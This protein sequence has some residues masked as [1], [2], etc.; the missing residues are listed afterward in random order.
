MA[1]ATLFGVSFLV[2]VA[3]LG[4]G[5]GNSSVGGGGGGAGGGAGGGV[6]GGAGGGTGQSC[7]PVGEVCGDNIDN[8][9]DGVADEGFDLDADGYKS[10]QGDCD[11]TRASINPGVAELFNQLDDNCDGKVDNKAPGN[12]FDKDLTPFPQDCNDEEPLVGPL[13]IEVAGDGVDNNCDGQ[14]DEAAGT[15]DAQATSVTPADFARVL[16]M[17]SFVTGSQFIAGDASARGIRTKFGS[18]WVPKQGSKM[19]LLTTGKALDKFDS[20][21]YSPQ[22]G[23]DFSQST[24]HPLYA[25]PKCATPSSTPTANDMSEVRF[26]LKVPQNAKSF[27]YQFNFFSAEYPE[28]VCTAFNDRFIAILES[29]GLDKT[30]LPPGQCVATAQRP[31]CNIS[32]D[33]NGQVMSINNGFFDVC[34]S[35]SGPG[36]SN[37]CTKPV[38]LLDKTG[39]E[40]ADPSFLQPNRIVGGATGWLT[41]KAPV[42]PGETM[43][44]RFII[45]DEG[46]GILDSAVLIDNFKWEATAVQAPETNPGIN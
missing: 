11:D 29:D 19:A 38:S 44:L 1:R 2:A 3:S 8:D 33:A 14:V 5:P 18:Q 6:G 21:T 23:H 46:D 37:T 15:C 7:I 26:T 12:D 36:W 9:C 24:A 20:S 17:C 35:A 42:K 22:D 41:T 39:Y 30:K 32:Y 4:C 27:S 40:E 28:F 16:G 10:C 25:P 43:T 31:T 34:I 45:F 13:A